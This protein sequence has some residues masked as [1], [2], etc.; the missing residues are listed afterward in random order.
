MKCKKCGSPID[1][2]I[3][4]PLCGHKNIGVSKCPVCNKKI[5]P[6]QEY[7]LECGSPTIYRKD[8]SARIKT[9]PSTYQTPRDKH[10]N[11]THQYTLEEGYDYKK[12]GYQS[13][14]TIK[15]LKDQHRK[16]S[17]SRNSFVR[18]ILITFIVVITVLPILIGAI[19]YFIE[20]TDFSFHFNDNDISNF[21]LEDDQ[22]QLYLH[23]DSYYKQG[24]LYVCNYD[25]IYV[26]DKDFVVYDIIDGSQTNLYVDDTY[27]YYYSMIDDQY[28][29]RNLESKEEEVLLYG[30]SSF[31]VVDNMVYY[32]QDMQLCSY[33]IDTKE[34]ETYPIKDIYQFYVNKEQQMIYFEE[35]E[36]IGRLNLTNLEKEYYD[37]YGYYYIFLEDGFYMH[38]DDGIYQYDLDGNQEEYYDVENVAGF[39]PVNNG[40]V[41]YDYD[42]CIYYVDDSG[43]QELYTGEDYLTLVEV[44]GG[45]ILFMTEEYQWYILDFDGNYVDLGLD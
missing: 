12:D 7:C 14:S 22:I 24:S 37:I 21:T 41:Y 19:G 4:C 45:N 35:E 42:D 3:I 38:D 5:L 26:F 13:H 29:R 15:T 25:G 28:I 16:H 9:T 36:K 10:T 43:E 40:I 31:Q 33:Q 8:V 17:Y 2:G 20:D 1:S 6:G 34:E 27:L 32:L 39:V 44:H 30:G 11:Q 23:Q 18:N